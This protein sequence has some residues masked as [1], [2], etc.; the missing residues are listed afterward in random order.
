MADMGIDNNDDQEEEQFDIL[1]SQNILS[2]E[3]NTGSAEQPA[4]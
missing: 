1:V 2:E 3:Y 4:A